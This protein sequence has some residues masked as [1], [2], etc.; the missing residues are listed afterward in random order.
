MSKQMKHYPPVGSPDRLEEIMDRGSGMRRRRRIL[1]ATSAGLMGIACVALVIA[2]GGVSPNTQKV[3]TASDDTSTQNAP[4]TNPPGQETT[5]STLPTVPT[6][7]ENLPFLSVEIDEGIHEMRININDLE[8]PTPADPT[9]LETTSFGVQQCVLVALN[10]TSEGDPLETEGF[11]CRSVE[12]GVPEAAARVPV[13]LN[14]P[15]DVSVGCAAFEERFEGPI[16]MTTTGASTEF[17]A[18]ISDA[19]LPAGDYSVRITA[20]SGFGDGCPGDGSTTSDP[21]T[22]QVENLDTITTAFTVG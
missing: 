13:E 11:W 19:D 14:S 7:V 10:R 4:E 8:T 6:P 12:P 15:S 2:L 3:A 1:G 20:V 9:I 16:E 21:T 18:S 17:V 5:L 22:A